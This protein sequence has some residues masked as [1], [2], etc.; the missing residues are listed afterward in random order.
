MDTYEC[1]KTKREVREFAGRPIP[2]EVLRTILNAGRL[3]GSSK[4][5]QPWHFVVVRDRA[6]LTRLSQTGTWAGH[7]ARAAAAVAIVN[8]P[9]DR[10]QV[11]FDVGRAAQN[12]VL[13]AWEL[14]VAS[15]P[16]AI[17]QE[18][19]AKAILGVPDELELHV[20]LSFGYPAETVDLSRPPRASGRRAFEEVVH[21]EGWEAPAR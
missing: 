17:Y 4:N 9:A 14:G 7:L 11:M 1:I 18:A 21:W 2:D 3:A 6:T 5:T 8:A 15:V 10:W 13:A 20:A 16:A 19:D 12:M